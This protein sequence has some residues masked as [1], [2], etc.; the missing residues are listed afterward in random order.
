MMLV[1]S[2]RKKRSYAIVVPVMDTGDLYLEGRFWRVVTKVEAT[3]ALNAAAAYS[4]RKDAWAQFLATD[5]EPA[6]DVA[7]AREPLSCRS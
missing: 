4:K 6:I 5:Y 1:V 7:T 2:S 3:T